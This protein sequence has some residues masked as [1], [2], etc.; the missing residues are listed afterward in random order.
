MEKVN[1][2]VIPLILTKGRRCQP[3]KAIE[4]AKYCHHIETVSFKKVPKPSR[5]LDL[6]DTFNCKQCTPSDVLTS[7]IETCAASCTEAL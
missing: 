4:V 6:D 3:H 7:L 2:K 1:E 5:N